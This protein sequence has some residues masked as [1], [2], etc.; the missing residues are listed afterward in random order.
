MSRGGP[1]M[2]DR[3]RGGQADSGGGGDTD[4]TLGTEDPYNPEETETRGAANCQHKS[5]LALDSNKLFLKFYVIY[6]TIRTFDTNCLSHSAKEWPLVFSG[7][8]M[9]LLFS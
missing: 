5:Y 7:V 9:A 1:L 4:G 6:D 8:T 3:G 2:A